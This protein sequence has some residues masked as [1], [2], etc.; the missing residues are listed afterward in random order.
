MLDI[1]KKTGK[2]SAECVCVRCNSTYTV[3]SIYGAKK[4]PVGDL[5]NTCK[6]VIPDMVNP[7]QESLLSVFTYKEDTGELLHK[8]TTISGNQDDL[9]T[10]DHSSGYLSVCV[11]KKQYLAHRIIY[12]MQTGEFPE[13]TDHINHNKR[14]NCW[15]NL[16]DVSQGDNNRNMPKQTNSSTG[17]VGVSMHKPTGK[18]RAYISINGRT[19]HLGL[20]GSVT[21]AKAAREAASIQNGYHS[22]HG[23]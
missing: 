12:L 3:K 16:R 11:G 4:S 22:N 14:D 1:I 17:I 23:K 18:Y 6:N 13:H 20:F 21:A 5:C 2:F 7:T 19:R 9:A 8:H 10:F 15:L